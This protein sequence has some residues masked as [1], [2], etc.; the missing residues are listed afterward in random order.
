MSKKTKKKAAASPTT[1]KR[2]PL[3]F[4]GCLLALILVILMAVPRSSQNTKLMA[5]YDFKVLAKM[6]HDPTAYTQGLLYQDGLFYESTGQNGQSSVRRVDPTSGQVLLRRDLD[7]RYFGEGLALFKG[8]L[9]QLTWRSG[10]VFVYNSDT[11]EPLREH[12]YQGEGWGL[13]HDGSSLIMS[14]GSNTL[15]FRDPSTFAI[16]KT[17]TVKGGPQRLNEL[18]YIKGEIWA[19]VYFTNTVLRISPT[20]GE[21]LGKIDFSGILA[22]ADRNGH[23]DVLNGIAYDTDSAR[24]FIT[25]KRYSYIYE[26]ALQTKP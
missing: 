22:P 20:D 17:I 4:M 19:N 7:N 15:S 9:F 16:T 1:T 6:P 24:L 11:L 8:A 23:E 26:V 12:H 13:T 14:N 25:G 2:H 3:I 21:L 18:E 5:H 10:R